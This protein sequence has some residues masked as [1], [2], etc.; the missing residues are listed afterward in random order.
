VRTA[1]QINARNQML[2]RRH[3]SEWSSR[4]FIVTKD[5]KFLR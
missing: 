1:D 2:R 3:P 4:A 5:Y